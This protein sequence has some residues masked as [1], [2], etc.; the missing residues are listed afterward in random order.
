M[1]TSAHNHVG[2]Q[3]CCT[4]P[5]HTTSS[6][7][8]HIT[9]AA[10]EVRRARISQVQAYQHTRSTA[11]IQSATQAQ[12]FAA[13]PWSCNSLLS[14]AYGVQPPPSGQHVLPE[15]KWPVQQQHQHQQ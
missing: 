15:R 7:T 9:H 13:T 2:P 4:L 11:T 14:A 8:L 6:A 5:L 1:E 3:I 10:G 12:K